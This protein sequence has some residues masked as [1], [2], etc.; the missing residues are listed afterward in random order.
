MC[1]SRRLS[2]STF[3]TLEV[4]EVVRGADPESRRYWA[5]KE[6]GRFDHMNI[7]KQRLWPPKIWDNPRPATTVWLGPKQRGRREGRALFLAVVTTQVVIRAS[8]SFSKARYLY[9]AA[10]QT[11]RYVKE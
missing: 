9:L 3:D 10:K 4:I 2:V 11:T 6:G 1:S 7:K 5:A 8:T